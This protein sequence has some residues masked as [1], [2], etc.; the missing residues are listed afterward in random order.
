M[1]EVE[2]EKKL[3]HFRL[4]VSFTAARGCTGILGASGCGKSMTLKQIAGVV[5]PDGGRVALDDSVFFDSGRKLDVKPRKRGIGYMFQ[6]YALF[7][8]M[9]VEENIGCAIAGGRKDRRARIEGKMREYR[10]EDLSG[11]YPSQLSGGQ[12]QRV[13]LARM[14]AAAPRLL[15]LDE[16]F[17]AM[18][19]YLREGLRLQLKSEI[20]AFNGTTL[21]VT[22]DRDEVYQLA[23]QLLLMDAGRIVRSG[24]TK[25]LFAHPADVTSAR[26]TGCKNLA[27]IEKTDA[28][29]VRVPDYDCILHT[30][31]P[32][33]ST[34]AYIGIRAHDFIPAAAPTDTD[35]QGNLFSTAGAAVTEMPFEWYVTLANGLWWKASKSL[36]DT[37]E[38]FTLPAYLY[39]PPER[40]LLLSP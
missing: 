7:P 37:K 32:V 26:L 18:D 33:E 2:I 9:T 13:A 1:L 39:A 4:A 10:I 27:K 11:M 6:S 36:Y 19:A 40:L 5:T 12:Q 35:A 22:H 16:P 3:K 8:N 25:E 21:L 31:R 17:S 29:T 38:H 24:P 23:D 20:A 15:L 34:D 14:M 28:Y 30:A